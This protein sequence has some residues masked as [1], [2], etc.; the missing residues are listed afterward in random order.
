MRVLERIKG[1]VWLKTR[2]QY[3]KISFRPAFKREKQFRNGTMAIE[4]ENCRI[5]LNEEI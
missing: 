3:L 2:K 5:N 4:K 1:F